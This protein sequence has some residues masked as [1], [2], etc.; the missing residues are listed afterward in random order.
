MRIRKY[1]QIILYVMLILSVAVG[2]FFYW[3]GIPQLD[4]AINVAKEQ[5][6]KDV[7]SVA[8]PMLDIVLQWTFLLFTIALCVAIVFQIVDF[9]K[10]LVQDTKSALKSLVYMIGLALVVLIAWSVAD[11]TLI[12]IHNYTGSFLTEGWMVATDTLLFSL[13]A[14]IGLTFLTVVVTGVIEALR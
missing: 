8:S 3:K 14:L 13:Y 9:A 11:P 1:T 2:V 12:S 5:G 4:A 7:G 6:I 10:K